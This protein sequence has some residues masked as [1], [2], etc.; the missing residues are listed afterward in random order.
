GSR[1]R[2]YWAS[3]LEMMTVI[4]RQNHGV[5]Q[6]CCRAR[7][8]QRFPSLHDEGIERLQH[9]ALQRRIGTF[10]LVAGKLSDDHPKQLT[11]YF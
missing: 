10:E 5:R 11:A 1:M 3:E 6:H 9:S 4:R 7:P 8:R 2:A